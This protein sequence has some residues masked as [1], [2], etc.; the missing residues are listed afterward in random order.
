MLNQIEDRISLNSIIYKI[1]TDLLKKLGGRKLICYGASA[2]W[3][4]INRIFSIWDLVEFCVDGDSSLWGKDYYGRVIKSPEELD[5]VD[6]T[7]Y[8]VV[9]FSSA[10][11]AISDILDGKGWEKNLNYYNISQYISILGDRSISPLNSFLRFLDTVPSDMKEVKVNKEKAGNRIGIVLVMEALN[12][13]ITYVPYLVSLFLLLKWKGYDVKLIVE[14]LHWDGDIIAYEGVCSVYDEIRDIIIRKLERVIPKEDIL[15]I[16]PVGNQK[17][18]EEDKKECFWIAD[19]SAKWSKWYNLFTVRYISEDR[20][21]KEYERIYF[22]NLPYIKQFFEENHFDV[23]N[24]ITAEHKMAGL[25]NY[26]AG[27]KGIR[28]SSQ[29]GADGTTYI[30][31][32]GPALHSRD[33]QFLLKGGWS[34]GI[35]PDDIIEQA[36]SMW[37]KRRG[38]TK[39]IKEDINFSEYSKDIEKEG[40]VCVNFQ[41]MHEVELDQKYEVVIPMNLA[42][43]GAMIGIKSIFQDQYEWLKKT[44]DFVINTLNRG[45]LIREHPSAKILPDYMECCELYVLYPELLELYKDNSLFRYVRSDEDLNIYQYIEQCKVVIPWTSTTGVETG[46]MKK[47][48]LVHTNAFYE[49]ACFAIRARSQQEYFQILK[50]CVLGDV[51]LVE[52]EQTAFTEALKYFYCTMHLNLKTDFT[53]INSD[54]LP[55]K[56]KDFREFINAKGVEEIVQIVAE[57]VPG[58]YLIEKQYR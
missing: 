1:E 48:L 52:N 42:Y 14:H 24:V 4:D 6:K 46:I 47:N 57:G 55:W 3:T 49:E 22:D 16:E 13:G 17:L 5:A 7:Q 12:Y 36:K 43:D 29:D 23:I 33:T 51:W 20:L 41:T 53:I 34:K 26:I 31:A 2:N 37:M 21:K 27:K 30:S 58:P 44:I 35:L 39:A 38:F 9:V 54:I 25:Y 10:F 28:V 50:E 45:V 8:A 18:S 40:Y 11:D 32:Y 15:Y 56:F 19:Y